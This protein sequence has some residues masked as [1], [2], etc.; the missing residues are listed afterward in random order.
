MFTTT[1]LLGMAGAATFAAM[2]MFLRMGKMRRFMQGRL[3]RLAGVALIAPVAMFALTPAATF[4]ASVRPNEDVSARVGVALAVT[5]PATLQPGDAFSY[6]ITVTNDG[7]GSANSMRVDLPLDADVVV[8]DFNSSE[9]NA[10]VQTLTFDM[11]SVQFHDLGAGT[12]TTATILAHINADAP[13][14]LTISSRA[15]ANWND[16]NFNRTSQSDGVT[17]VVGTGAPPAPTKS[18]AISSTDPVDAGTMLTV[19][20][21]IYDADEAVGVWLNTPDG[22]ILPAESLGQTDSTLS[23]TVV[24]LD[25]MGL[26]DG[27]GMLTYNLDTTG[28]PSGTYSLVAQGLTSGMQGVVSFTIK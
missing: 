4:A 19:S 7:P 5:G 24:G 12:V 28:L 1:N 21:S 23:G 10:F 15:T 20:G 18:L 3:A 17:L 9:A 11:I 6:Q 26:T 2:F 14:A 22:I 25:A 27:A 8:D 16:V 13:A